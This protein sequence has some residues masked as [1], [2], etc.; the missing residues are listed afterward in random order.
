MCDENAQ[1]IDGDELMAIIGCHM[2]RTD[3]LQ[4]KTLVAT[5]MSNFG[6][7]ECISKNGGKVERAGIGDRVMELMKQIGSNFG[8]EPVATLYAKIIIL[9]MELLPLLQL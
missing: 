2:L 1:P 9:V 6:L 5:K 4:S 3:Q 8:G 7:D